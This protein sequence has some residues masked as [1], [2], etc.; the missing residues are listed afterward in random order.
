MDRDRAAARRPDARHRRHHPA[1]AGRDRPR[2]TSRH[3]LRAGSARH[4][5]DRR[6]PAPGGVPAVRAPRPAAPAPARWSSARTRPS[7]TTSSRSC[8]PSASCEVRQAT[9][10]D[11]VAHV[12][13]R[14]TDSP[15]AAAP[16]G[17]RAD[18]AGAAPGRPVASG[19]PA[20]PVVVVRGSRRWRVPAYELPRDRRGVAGPRHP[21]R[22]RARALPQR[23]AHAVLVQMERSGEAPDDRVQDAVARNPAVKAAVRRSGR[24]RPGEARAAAAVRRGLPGRARRRPA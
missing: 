12:E 22:R 23:I 14:G 13:V 15:D 20:E 21:L 1:R 24:R 2:R 5:E 6:R 16:Q 9:V 7:S 3:G 18:G 17:R 10:D 4:R 11:L 8:P 19:P